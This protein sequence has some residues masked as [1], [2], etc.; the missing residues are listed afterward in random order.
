MVNQNLDSRYVLIT[1]LTSFPC[2]DHGG[3][4]R[5]YYGSIAI[6]TPA[7][8]YDVILDTGSSDL[9][10]V[11]SSCTSQACS[12]VPTFNPSSSSSFTSTNQ[13]FAVTYGSGDAS[14]TLG[15]DVVQMA[16]FEVNNQVFGMFFIAYPLDNSLMGFFFTSDV[17]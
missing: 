17:Q 16:G 14:G 3:Y 9:F 15:K 7:V 11:S 13:A 4:L 10:L 2:S 6:G 8:A 1:R 5:S 12:G